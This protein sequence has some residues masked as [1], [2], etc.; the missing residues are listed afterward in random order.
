[1]RYGIESIYQVPLV[2]FYPSD[3]IHFINIKLK[4]F[5]FW[6]VLITKIFSLFIVLRLQQLFKYILMD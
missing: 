5:F 6:L 1:M 4:K 3:F 2:I